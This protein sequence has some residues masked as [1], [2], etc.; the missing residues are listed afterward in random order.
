[1][2]DDTPALTRWVWVELIG[3]DNE[4]PDYGVRHYLDT[5]GFVPDLVS[6]L[7][8]NPDFVHTHDGMGADR[9]LPFDCLVEI[10]RAHV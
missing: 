8:F 7:L 2:A 4:S 5:A 1:L 3:F 9:A 10:G 6:F